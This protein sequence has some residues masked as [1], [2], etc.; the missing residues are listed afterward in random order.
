MLLAQRFSPLEKVRP[1]DV[2]RYSK[3]AIVFRCV[4]GHDFEASLHNVSDGAPCP[5]CTGRSVLAGFNDVATTHPELAR[6]FSKYSPV[7]AREV[8]KGSKARAVF[9]CEAELC[10][11]EWEATVASSLRGSGFCFECS[12]S[13]K[14]KFEKSLVVTHGELL[15]Y[16]SKRNTVGPEFYSY[17]SNKKVLWDCS[18]CGETFEK[19]VESFISRSN[20]TCA[21]CANKFNRTSLGETEV[22]EFLNSVHDSFQQSVRTVINPYELDCYSQV[23]ELAVEF[24]GD[25]WHSDEMIRATRGMGALEYHEMKTSRCA[26][27]GVLLIHVSELEWKTDTVKVKNTLSSIVAERLFGTL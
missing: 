18:D 25:Y 3:I 8:S 16:W 24:N 5:F 4:L 7:S 10:E 22:L 26:E 2:K 17:G 1:H 12:H 13:G 15:S 21:D 11:V 20:R 9:V 6:R 14:P 23:L 27:V 19:T